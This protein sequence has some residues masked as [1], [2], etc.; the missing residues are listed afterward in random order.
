MRNLKEKSVSVVIELDNAAFETTTVW[1]KRVR[2]M[3]DWIKQSSEVNVIEIIIAHGEHYSES[4]KLF[5]S[6]L[7]NDWGKNVS[8]LPLVDELAYYYSM[9]NIGAQQA[10]G[11]IIAFLDSDLTPVYGTF[12]D[13]IAPLFKDKQVAS[14]GHAFFPDDNFLSK[15]YSLF[16]FFPIYHEMNSLSKNSLYANSIV[17]NR[18][19]F[20]KNMFETQ[21]G[22]LRVSCYL[23]AQHLKQE[24]Y[25][26]NHPDVWFEHA[27]WNSTFGFFIWRAFVSGRDANKKQTIINS[28]SRII[29][30]KNATK[31]FLL[32]IRRIYKRHITYRHNVNMG[33]FQTVA[34]FFIGIVFFFLLRSSQLLSILKPVNNKRETIP[35]NYIT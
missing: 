35:N 14:C 3:L 30:L 1:M 13:L 28:K 23:Q 19:W 18:D 16:W 17:F 32:D 9:K 24:G 22:G 6:K 26:I 5:L 21:C 10:K 31:S 2:G 25:T 29:R 20:L 4:V 12:A 11:E 34:S 15:S 8:S 33:Y 7:P 27:L